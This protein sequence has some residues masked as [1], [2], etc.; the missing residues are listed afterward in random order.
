MPW[1]LRYQAGWRVSSRLK[2]L[3][4]RLTHRHCTVE[5][6]GP[7]RL[8]RGFRLWIPDHGTF[9][10]GPGAD[11]REGFVCEIS[12]GGVV[13]IGA[14]ATFTSHALI[15]CTTAVTIGD[16]CTF[17][18]SLLIADG[19][20]RFRDPDQPLAEQGYDFRPVTIGDDVLV[21]TKCTVLNDIG[22]HSVIGA[23]SLVS[24]PI[25]SYCLAVGTPAR[26]VE[27]FARGEPPSADV[28]DP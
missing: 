16:R 12:G 10:V 6:Q 14:L 3:G 25:P 7:A 19:N 1:W 23:H 11:F 15:Q 26:V 2:R 28:M 24:K 8:G 4:I 5:F 18:Q 13:R 21:T 22:E 9:V 20:H 17:G 27:R